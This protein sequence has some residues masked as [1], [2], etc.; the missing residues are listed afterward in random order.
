MPTLSGARILGADRTKL[1]LAFDTALDGSVTLANTVFAVKKTPDG[2]T[3]ADAPLSTTAPSIS[4]KRVTLTLASAVLASDAVKVSY[5][6]PTTGT[7]NTIRSAFR[8]EAASFSGQAAAHNR[9][10]VFT[11]MTS[12]ALQSPRTNPSTRPLPW[13]GVTVPTPQ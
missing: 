6:K 5:T 12:A 9:A 10:P 4:G 8:V 2:G 13:Y 11:P 3:E 1:L 7:N